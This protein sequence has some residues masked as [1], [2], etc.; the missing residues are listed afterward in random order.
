MLCKVFNCGP[1]M[2]Y[3]MIGI[4]FKGLASCNAWCCFYE[5]NRISQE[6]LSVVAQ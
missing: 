5:F 3:M 6:V 4:F 1:E 2:E